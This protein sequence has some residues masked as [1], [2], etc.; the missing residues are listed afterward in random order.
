MSTLQLAR[1]E[2]AIPAAEL[3]LMPFHIEYTGFAPVTTYFRPKPA[4]SRFPGQAA[5]PDDDAL[6]SPNG[7]SQHVDENTQDTEKMD[8]DA[9][10]EPSTSA[11]TPSLASRSQSATTDADPRRLT[12]A[13]RGRTVQGLRVDLPA[14]YSG[15]VL[16]T[17]PDALALK[18]EGERVRAKAAA[19]ASKAEVAAKTKAK[20]AAAASEASTRRATRRSQRAGLVVPQAEPEAAGEEADEGETAERERDEHNSADASE[21]QAG[22]SEDSATPAVRVLR[23]S[24]TFSSF[25]LWNADIA[26]DEGKDEYLRTITEWMDL[27]AE[28]GCLYFWIPYRSCF[29][30]PPLLNVDCSLPVDSRHACISDSGDPIS[31]SV[32]RCAT[33]GENARAISSYLLRP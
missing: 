3:H 23:P 1:P 31:T 29:T 13:F 4:N 28:V 10:P 2:G 20:K 17:P 9:P 21:A 12:A 6:M 8:V 30:D 11:A 25:V 24:A 22:D 33:E 27:A 5:T 18:A 15:A 16:R 14:G 26:V 7:N 19:A 32:R